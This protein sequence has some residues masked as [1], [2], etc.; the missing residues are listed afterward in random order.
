MKQQGQ[1][2]HE[3]KVRQLTRW[4]SGKYMQ[5]ILHLRIC[6]GHCAEKGLRAPTWVVSPGVA[7]TLQKST[8]QHCTGLRSRGKGWRLRCAQERRRRR[9]STFRAGG[10]IRQ[11]LLFEAEQADRCWKNYLNSYA[12]HSEAR[13]GFWPQ[14]CG[15]D[16]SASLSSGQ[17]TTLSL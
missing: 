8:E 11:L 3:C 6:V 10:I 14:L 16:V 9:K 17:I 2:Q 4:A 13:T 5:M 7:Y 12:V 1:R 15:W